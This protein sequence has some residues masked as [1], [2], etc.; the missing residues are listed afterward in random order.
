MLQDLSCFIFHPLTKL[1]WDIYVILLF[2][3]LER[4]Y[5]CLCR[6]EILCQIRF[7]LFFRYE[8]RVDSMIFKE[9]FSS[10]LQLLQSQI[11]IITKTTKGLLF[12]LFVSMKLRGIKI[13]R[14]MLKASIVY[15]LLW[16]EMKWSKATWSIFSSSE[17]EWRGWLSG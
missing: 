11:D 8:V 13:W 10:R 6:S 9:D 15:Y 17:G 4:W 2:V 5:C 7:S 1:A 12:I 3:P 16:D 14:Y